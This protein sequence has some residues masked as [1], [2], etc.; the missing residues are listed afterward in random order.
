[1]N[2]RNFSPDQQLLGKIEGRF[3]ASECQLM[4]TKP[5]EQAKSLRRGMVR[6]YRFYI[7]AEDVY[8][9]A[10]YSVARSIVC[11]QAATRLLF[12]RL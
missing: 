5:R 2:K 7:K 3:V 11:S 4:P 1:M 6:L 8:R 10:P 12:V 9:H